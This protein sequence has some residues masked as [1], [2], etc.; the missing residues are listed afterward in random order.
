[1]PKKRCRFCL[2]LEKG[3][4]LIVMAFSGSGEIPFPDILVSQE[5]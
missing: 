3:M 1:M 2:D 5:Y 4:S